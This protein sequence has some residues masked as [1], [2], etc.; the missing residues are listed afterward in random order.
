MSLCANTSPQC[1]QDSTISRSRTSPNLPPPLGKQNTISQPHIRQ[2]C[3]CS[4]AYGEAPNL[5]FT[6]LVKDEV[7][8]GSSDDDRAEVAARDLRPGLVVRDSVGRVLV[9]GKIRTIHEAQ[10]DFR[11]WTERI[12]DPTQKTFTIVTYRRPAS[13][14]SS[15]VRG[16]EAYLPL[17]R[18]GMG[19][20]KGGRK[21]NDGYV[22]LVAQRRGGTK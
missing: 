9:A 13:V 7:R 8:G 22:C 21:A 20:T 12:C 11:V 4:D 15:E 18:R 17:A 3:D 19:S 1:C 14:M 2:P 5:P 10:G 16:P 6:A